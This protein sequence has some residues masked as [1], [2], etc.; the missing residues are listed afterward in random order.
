VSIKAGQIHP[1]G[2]PKRAPDQIPVG[3]LEVPVGR[4]HTHTDRRPV[5]Q[6]R[7]EAPAAQIDVLVRPAPGVEQ[8]VTLSSRRF[9]EDNLSQFAS[10][11]EVSGQL[12]NHETPSQ[13]AQ[14]QAV[15]LEQRTGCLAPPIASEPTLRRRQRR[16]SA[17][18][19]EELAAAYRAGAP[20]N[21]L[22]AQFRI[23]RSTVLDHLNRSD[24]PRRYPAL[25]SC[26]VEEAARFYEAGQSLRAI[27]I[28]FGRHAS[29]VR[30]ALIKAGVHT[31]GRNGRD[32]TRRSE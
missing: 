31:R 14:L 11:V 9:D 10:P 28:H 4:G 18:Q 26:Q 13:I 27:G 30:L 29:T 24:T 19:V 3:R 6:V 16:L 20:V 21:D 1:A 7:P 23:H 2:S 8:E 17:A 5:H 15:V 22:A 32:A 12:S 25:D